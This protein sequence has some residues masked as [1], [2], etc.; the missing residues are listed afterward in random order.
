MR[1][2]LQWTGNDTQNKSARE[3]IDIRIPTNG[4][5]GSL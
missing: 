3:W 5:V 4:L 1:A 2:L